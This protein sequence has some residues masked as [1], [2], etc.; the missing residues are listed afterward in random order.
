MGKRR[1]QL[2]GAQQKIDDELKATNIVGGYIGSIICT[3]QGL[4]VASA[5]DIPSDE[6]LAGFASLFDEIVHR[7]SR[8]LGLGEIDE[9]TVLDKNAGR[10]VIRPVFPPSE[11]GAQGS[12]LFLVMWMDADATWRRNA[13]RLL[14]SL[15]ELLL[16]FVSKPISESPEE[17]ASD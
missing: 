8:H 13:N 17:V 6:A 4:L 2:K 12:R 5:G 14:V 9:A 11:W 16:P 7:G 10:L 3:D 15:R 1:G